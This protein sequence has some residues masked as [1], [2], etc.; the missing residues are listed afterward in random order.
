[1]SVSCPTLNVI[2]RGLGDGEPGVNLASDRGT[3]QTVVKAPKDRLS[4]KG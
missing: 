2:T 1:M 3:S 4:V